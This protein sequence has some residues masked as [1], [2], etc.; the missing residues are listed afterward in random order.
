MI[1]SVSDISE[2]MSQIASHYDI[3]RVW[4]FGSFARGEANEQS[5][6]DLCL[7][8][9]PDFSLFDAG[10]VGFEVE[11]LLGRKVDIVAE[12]TLYPHVRECMLRDR[13]LVYEGV[14]L[15]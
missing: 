8:T 7:E 12:D 11:Q 2:A 14:G 9:G 15:V 6:I 1:P 3:E 5:D 13:V 4:L 10:G